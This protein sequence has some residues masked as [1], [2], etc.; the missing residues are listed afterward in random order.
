MVLARHLDPDVEEG[1]AKDG[2]VDES[3]G[4]GVAGQ[5]GGQREVGRSRG[6]A[7]SV[8]AIFW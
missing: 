1:E 4:Q 2:A 3:E 7:G 8:L 6:R 5:E